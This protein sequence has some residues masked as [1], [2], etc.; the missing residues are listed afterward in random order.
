MQLDLFASGETPE[1]VD[2]E[3]FICRRC[4]L[5]HPLSFRHYTNNGRHHVSQDCKTCYAK[6][7]KVRRELHKTAPPKPDVCDCCE[8]PFPPSKLFLDHC[9]V[10]NTFRGWLC[11]SCNMGMGGLGDN[12]EGLLKGIAYLEKAENGQL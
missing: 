2:E 12:K 9:H 7:L 8:M 6:T 1:H 10:K 5:E 4:G 3:T 11:N